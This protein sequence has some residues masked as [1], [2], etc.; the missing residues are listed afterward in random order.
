MALLSVTPPGKKNAKAGALGNVAAIMKMAESVGGLYGDFANKPVDIKK[1][2]EG[3]FMDA[4]AK[5]RMAEQLNQTKDLQGYGERMINQKGPAS[6][7]SNQPFNVS[8]K[9]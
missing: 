4:Y 7:Y 5:A 6:M 2:D 1:F 8:K 3:A 9:L